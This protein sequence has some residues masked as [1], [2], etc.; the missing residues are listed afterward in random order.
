[1]AI[2]AVLSG[3]LSFLNLAE[4]LQL[5][6]SNTSTGVLRIN[7][8]YASE[9]GVVFFVKGNPVH[10]LNDKRNGM[11]AIFSLFGWSE[12]EFTFSEEGYDGQT[13]IK[14]SRMEII[15]DGLRKLD[16]GEIE[17]LEPIAYE[18]EPSKPDK[19]KSP[20]PVIK[21]PLVDYLHVVDEEEFFDGEEI[22]IEGNHGNWIW[23]ILEGTVEL[24]KT[25]ADG[26]VNFIKISDGAF[27]GSLSSL[28]SDDSVRNVTATAVGNVQLGMLDSQGLGS[29][30]G[31]MSAQFQN[32][33]RSIDKR[34]AGV[35]QNAV[36]TYLQQNDP[37]QVLKD[38]RPVIMEGK[39]DDKAFV[40][41]GGNASV[42]RKTDAG[43]VLLVSSLGEGDVIG[44]ISFLDMGLEPAS[45][46]VMGDPD[47]KVTKLDLQ[48]LNYEHEQLSSTFKNILENLSTCILATA[49]VTCEFKRKQNKKAAA[50]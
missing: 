42:V 13:T 39:N 23:V 47:L 30:F 11:D 5:L 14:K 33:I 6:G 31:R 41:T 48:T 37:K 50:Q 29:E 43:T 2:K 45:A 20:I 36:D 35:M 32:L 34:F 3:N 46:I 10:A 44:R 4:L 8:R 27:I 28:L 12:G 21:G 22:I 17:R 24:S 16:D 19:K 25:T 7:N 15:L 38:R 1:M 18:K 49:M 9:P 26:P 40:I